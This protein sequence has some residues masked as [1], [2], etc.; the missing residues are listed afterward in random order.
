MA[1]NIIKTNKISF[2]VVVGFLV[3]ILSLFIYYFIKFRLFS[4]GDFF[5]LLINNKP[6][7]TGVTIICLVLNIIVFTL[8]INSNRDKTAIGIFISTFLYAGT[9][10]IYKYFF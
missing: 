8:Y 4:I 7:L 6:F 10:I 9:S 1:G 3:P 2:G 5:R